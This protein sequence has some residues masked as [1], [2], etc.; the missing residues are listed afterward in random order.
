MEEYMR[1]SARL[2]HDT[3]G[4]KTV[5]LAGVVLADEADPAAPKVT[6][7]FPSEL[8]MEGE[9]NVDDNWSTGS[10]FRRFQSPGPRDKETPTGPFPSYTKEG[11]TALQAQLSRAVTMLCAKP[12][13]R[14]RHLLHGEAPRRRRQLLP[15]AFGPNFR[16][17]QIS[18]PPYDDDELPAYIPELLS[19]VLIIGFVVTF[20]FTTKS[21]TEEKARQIKE[22]LKIIGVPTSLHWIAWFIKTMSLLLITM[23]LVVVILKTPTSNGAI[24]KHSSLIVVFIF[25]VLFAAALTF[26][27][28]M[29]SSIF[30]NDAGQQWKNIWSNPTS[31]YPVAMGVVWLFLLLNCLMYMLI[32]LY[33]DAILP[34]EYGMAKPWNFLCQADGG[35]ERASRVQ[36]SFWRPKPPVEA[37]VNPLPHAADRRNVEDEPTGLRAGVRINAVSKV[38]FRPSAKEGVFNALA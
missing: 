38:R 14:R 7:R 34:G 22:T 20:V 28:F 36:K 21:L 26:F 13:R 18:Y 12:P 4:N 10:N 3:P 25:F 1:T 11:F 35:G 8:R 27:A 15:A 30:S 37:V 19:T 6:L 31:D 16:L 17:R 33:V 9:E 24:L 32:T 5:T 29:L 23:V 2:R